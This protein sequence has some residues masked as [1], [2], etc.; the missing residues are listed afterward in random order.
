VQFGPQEE[1]PE[2]RA[3]GAAVVTAKRS[4]RG[5]F[6]FGGMKGGKKKP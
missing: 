2:E 5:S 3:P 4:K 6:L 1:P